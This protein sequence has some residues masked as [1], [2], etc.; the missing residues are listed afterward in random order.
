FAL[1]PF[2][3]RPPRRA[4]LGGLCETPASAY[5]SPRILELLEL[6]VS[7]YKRVRQCLRRVAAC[8]PTFACLG[9]EKPRLYRRRGFLLEPHPP[10]TSLLA[11]VR[12]PDVSPS[13]RRTSK[14]G[15]LFPS[16]FQSQRGSLSASWRAWGCR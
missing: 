10:V 9:D 3:R 2:R 16:R 6:N 12:P 4:S 11:K 13:R 15:A 7:F 14:D 5:A 1:K 8:Q